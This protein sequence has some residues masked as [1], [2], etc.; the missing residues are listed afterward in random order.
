MKFDSIV[1]SEELNRIDFRVHNVPLCIVNAARRAILAEVQCAAFGYD[2]CIPDAPGT[3][4]RVVANTSTLHNEMLAHRFSFLPIHLSEND[5]ERFKTD[6]TRYKFSLRS[7]NR[8][9]AGAMPIDVTSRDIHVADAFGAPLPQAVRDSMFPPDRITGDHVLLVCLRPS[10]LGDGLGE[11]V[12]IDAVASSSSGRDNCRW[13]P[14]SLCAFRNVVDPRLAAE[15]YE[16]LTLTAPD[17]HPTQVQSRA[18]FNTLDAHR[19]FVR[20]A[21]GDPSVFD[22]SI[23]SV[24]GLRPEYVFYKALR[25]LSDLVSRLVAA[26][27]ALGGP[28]GPGPSSATMMPVTLEAMP[29]SDDFYALTI[30]HQ[31]HTLGNL[32]QGLLY[33]VHVRDAGSERLTFVGYHVAHPLE[34]SVCMKLKVVPGLSVRDFLTEALQDIVRR[35][36]AVALAWTH[37]SGLDAAGILDVDAFITG[38]TV[39][40]RKAG[41]GE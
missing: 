28:G 33:E 8:G 24:C 18:Q 5:Q 22:F 11:E 31:G 32:V 2:I 19:C 13:S 1:R 17:G 35:L 27:V 12:A 6:S 16:A 14:V 25:I 26:L 21:H 36:D 34:Q 10:P 7:K 29:N 30:A 38:R 15:A 3:G 39:L 4:V 40:A 37:P 20:D 9:A 41:T 23:E